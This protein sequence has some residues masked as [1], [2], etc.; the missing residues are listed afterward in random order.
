VKD[1]PSPSSLR[2]RKDGNSQCRSAGQHFY[3]LDSRNSGKYR[4][5]GAH[6][7]DLAENSESRTIK[8]PNV[9]TNP[10]A[11]YHIIEDSSFL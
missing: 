2:R 3:S 1:S 6:L 4:K 11:K 9:P 10:P 5:Q 8:S 7:E